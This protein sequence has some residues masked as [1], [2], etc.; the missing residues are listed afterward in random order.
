MRLLRIVD[1]F[2]LCKETL[3]CLLIIHCKIVILHAL[4]YTKFISQLIEHT[5]HPSVT[6][7]PI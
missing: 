4:Y 3:H 5:A 2:N 7:F 1:I 6:I